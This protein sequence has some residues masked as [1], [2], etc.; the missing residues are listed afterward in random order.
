MKRLC[1]Q[2]SV[3]VFCKLSSAMMIAATAIATL[4]APLSVVQATIYLDVKVDPSNAGYTSAYSYAVTSANQNTPVILDVYALIAT[5]S[6]NNSLDGF[7]KGGANFYLAS[8]TLKGDISSNVSWGS[9]VAAPP[10]STPGINFT[11]S[12]GGLALGGTSTTDAT[13]NDWWSPSMNT[14][15]TTGGVYVDVNGGTLTSSTGAIGTEIFLGTIAASFGNSP[16]PASSATA[17]LISAPRYGTGLTKPWQ[18]KEGATGYATFGSVP[19]IGGG[20]N[21][22]NV[23]YHG[24]TAGLNFTY[25]PIT[26]TYSLSASA[27]QTIIHTGGTTTAM[28][29]ITN[30][31]ASGGTLS[32][33]GL[34]LIAS[35]GTLSGA[36]LPK[37][38]GPLTPGTLDVGSQTLTAITPGTLTLTPTIGGVTPS[39]TL[40]SSQ[41]ITVSVFSGSAAWYGGSG[42][43]G[44]SGTSANWTD[45]VIPTIN[46]A[47]GVWGFAGDAATL[48]AGTAGTI[49]LD[50]PVS[51]GSLSLN[52]SAGYTLAAGSGGTLHANNGS[53]AASV[54]VLAGNHAITAPTVLDSSTSVTVTNS[55]DTLAISGAISG[56][57]GLTKLGPGT[58]SL[59]GSNTYSGNTT[60]DGGTVQLSN[61]QLASPAQYVGFSGSGSVTQSAGTNTASAALYLA[62]NPGSSGVYNLNGGLLN[63]GSLS[64]GSGTA[65]FNFGGGTLG[66]VTSWSS[67]LN[68]NLNGIGGPGTIDTTGG[69]IS[70]YGNLTGVGGLQKVGPGTLTLNGSNDF[71]GGTTISAG[72]LQVG[73]SS[74]LAV[75][76]GAVA[77]NGG[78]LDMHGFGLNVGTLSGSGVI[79]NQSPSSTATMIAGNGNATSD[80]AGSIRDGSG[81]VALAKVGTG[82]LTLSG[83][84][85][86]TGATNISGGTLVVQGPNASSSFTANSGGTLEFSGAS[87]NRLSYGFG[88]VR[89]M[90][91]SAVLYQNANM[92]GVVLRGPGP[93]VFSAGF[94]N[95]FGSTTINPGAVIQQQGST[96][97]SSVTNRGE[98]DNNAILTWN[99]GLNDGGGMLIVSSTATVSNWSNVGSVIVASGGVLNNHQADLLSLGGGT[100]TVNSGGTLNADSQ[101]ELVAIDLQASLLVNN[102]TLHGKVNVG[103]VGTAAGAGTFDAINVLSGGTLAVSPTAAPQSTGILV[104]QGAIVGS[105][106]LASPVTINSANVS[107]ANTTD[108]LTF[109]GLLAGTGSLTKTGS[110][111]LILSGTADTFNGTLTAAAGT[112]V[113]SNPQAVGN[114]TNLTVGDALAFPGAV[115]PVPDIGAFDVRSA[116]TDRTVTPVPEPGTLVLAIAAI[117]SAAIY[118]RSRSTRA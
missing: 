54:T 9:L 34:N 64:G 63:V 94:T 59:S 111:T 105:G 112:L 36:G 21:S 7:T 67:S 85:S 87:V 93:Q 96:T 26:T 50:G 114:G 19:L 49:T 92:I 88:D 8:S 53:G 79:N 17:P 11:S 81:Y 77:V 16:L 41:T 106:T 28:A 75:A 73:S 56:S 55:G 89:A 2:R 83:T 1:C 99:G 103:N 46:A 31:P 78:T 13:T 108:T 22:T 51:L 30:L 104:D 70:L 48:G 98:I 68:M 84:N 39:S 52:N 113:V 91:G 38:G 71:A 25:S 116:L 10:A 27:A 65:I 61:G 18:W 45:T 35:A 90:N 14:A 60:I 58:L 24:G 33:T 3:S 62:S 40:S 42:S 74:A 20:P 12:F 109:S 97:F 23:L 66:A 69:N 29:T 43:W 100:L 47:P 5:A 95:S 4:L 115:I 118:R 57:G 101:N 15:P 6:P 32:Y 102:G 117:L 72:V 44:T 107:V 37:D 76:S 82:I 86:Y 110:G 80:F